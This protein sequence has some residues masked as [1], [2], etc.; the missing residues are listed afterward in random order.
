MIF[1]EPKE[2]I[3]EGDKYYRLNVYL[4]KFAESLR[5]GMSADLIIFISFKDEALKIPELAIYDKGGKKFVKILKDNQQKEIEVETG[6]SD[7]EN[8]EVI[9]GLVEGQI[10]IVSQE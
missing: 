3:K 9:S 6:I 5:P 4:D 2:I 10:V 7:G 1:I 8:V